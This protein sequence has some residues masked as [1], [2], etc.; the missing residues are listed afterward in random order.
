LV[1]RV[2]SYGATAH[3]LQVKLVAAPSLPV[4]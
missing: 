1:N 3:A 4:A 2:R